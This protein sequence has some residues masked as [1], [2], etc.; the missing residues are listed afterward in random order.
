MTL[1]FLKTGLVV[2]ALVLN[3]SWF[4]MIAKVRRRETAALRWSEHSRLK[5]CNLYRKH[6]P[7][8]RLIVL[9]WIALPWAVGFFVVV[10]YLQFFQRR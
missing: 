4:L 8:S 10:S 6:Y 2:G 9:Y 5:V 1:I 3:I 7:G